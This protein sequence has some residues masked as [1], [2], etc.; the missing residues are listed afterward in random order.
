RKMPSV[1]Y[2]MPDSSHCRR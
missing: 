1:Y 2:V